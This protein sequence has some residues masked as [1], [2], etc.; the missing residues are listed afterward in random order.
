M[1][2]LLLSTPC[3]TPG[4]PVPFCISPGCPISVEKPQRGRK[5]QMSDMDESH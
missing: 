3:M 1:P 2:D 4:G 5:S